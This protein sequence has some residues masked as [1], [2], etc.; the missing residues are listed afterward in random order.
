MA[1]N[2]IETAK[3]ENGSK[4]YFELVIESGKDP[5]KDFST[6]LVA[7]KKVYS[8][9]SK[10]WMDSYAKQAKALKSY[11]GR[12]KGYEYSRDEGFMPFI[13][14]IAK[15]KCGVSI[16]DRWDPADIYMVRK[17]KRK[18][19]ESK[20]K[21]ITSTSD[22]ET[23][24]LALNDYM[25]ELMESFD[26][27]PISLKAIKKSTVKANIEPANMGGKAK[28]VNFEVVPGSVKCLLDFGHKNAHEFDTGE[29]A[30]DFKVGD[31]EIHGQARNFQYSKERN[32]VQTDLT[33]KGRSGGAKLGKVSSE[34]LDS[35]LTKARLPRPASASKDPNIDLPGK[36]TKE[37]I[38]YWIEYINNLKTKKVAGRFL[39]LGEL[40]VKVG[41]KETKGAEE[42]IKTA[43][44]SE[45]KTRSSAGRF[46]SKLIGLRWAYTWVLIE[47]KGLME[48]WLQTLY[49][50]AKKEFGGKNGPFLKIY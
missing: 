1:G 12:N 20:I 9:V 48:E 31:E 44:I 13:E 3:Q 37:N 45:G 5:D 8:N 38:D 36:W 41:N 14:N 29:F 4:V 28:Q 2:A 19:I 35:F 34:A 15:T 6:L 33:P 27:L 50:G 7:V 49:Y 17:T 25:R 23:N 24:L 46:S 22:T 11:I 47:E 43:I 18:S 21:E 42:V 10:E 30:F 26:M 39:D 40:K 32:L 16:K